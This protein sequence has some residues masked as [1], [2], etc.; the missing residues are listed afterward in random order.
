[1]RRTIATATTAAFL[2]TLG[3]DRR[4][5]PTRSPSSAGEVEVLSQKQYREHGFEMSVVV[6]RND[7]GMVVSRA[8]AADPSRRQST[9]S[10]ST[11]SK[12][13]LA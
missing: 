8:N 11:S 10:T 2:L 6:S 12:A 9:C 1:M 5:P 7:D 4:T 13:R 3:C